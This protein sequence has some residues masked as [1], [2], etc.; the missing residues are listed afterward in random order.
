MKWWR[1]AK[2]YGVIATAATAPWDIW[3]HYSA[4]EGDG[5]RTLQPGQEAEVEYIRFDQESFKYIARRVRVIA[6]PAGPIV[7]G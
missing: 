6:H 4:V 1:G 2:G 3:C 7:S 5:F